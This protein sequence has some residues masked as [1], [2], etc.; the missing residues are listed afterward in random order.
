MHAR[1]RF[2]A[3]FALG[4]AVGAATVWCALTPTTRLV[5][6]WLAFNRNPKG[7]PILTTHL[8]CDPIMLGINLRESTNGVEWSLQ[9]DNRT[10]AHTKE[11]V[12]T[13]IK[14]LVVR[15]PDVIVGLNSEP[16]LTVSNLNAATLEL[17]QLGLS[18]FFIL[19][20]PI[21]TKWN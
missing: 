2:V 7:A 13:A 18:R 10:V 1:C 21:K 14:E 9:F 3:V 12:S 11:Q 20:E 4:G 19:N 6:K 16:G 15:T 5:T 8:G 17:E